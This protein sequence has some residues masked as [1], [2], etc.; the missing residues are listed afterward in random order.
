MTNELNYSC[1]A[2][3]YQNRGALLADSQKP[4]NSRI[5]F[6]G[7]VGYMV[8]TP[9][10]RHTRSGSARI[11]HKYIVTKRAE[12]TREEWSSARSTQKILMLRLCVNKTQFI[13][14]FSLR[15]RGSVVDVTLLWYTRR[16]LCRE[17]CVPILLGYSFKEE[18]KSGWV[19][20][21][22]EN[23]AKIWEKTSVKLLNMLF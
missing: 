1:I 10:Y 9:I 12:D 11:Q 7:G 21:Y 18:T 16:H 19:F 14:L 20:F 4:F 6:A 5:S 8:T 3:M 15:T 17:T 23:S 22:K 13:I 2:I